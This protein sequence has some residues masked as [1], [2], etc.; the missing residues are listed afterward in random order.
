MKIFVVD[1]NVIWSLA[2]NPKS[3][4][5]QFIMA[6]DPDALKLY[7]PEYLREE[8]SNHFD[9]IVALSGQPPNVVLAI[10][11]LAYKKLNFISDEQIPFRFYKDAI[12]LL[13]DIDINDI[14]F[15]A[16]N[17]YCNSL[18][19]TGDRR[20]LNGLR[21]KGYQRVVDFSEVKSI[22]KQ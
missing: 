13:R 21:A 19:W 8:I 3:E 10:L 15:V 9:K 11:E 2:Y 17:D 20:L 1:S 5:G 18:L 12:P 7:A 22:M 16:L 4:I 14:V 6:S